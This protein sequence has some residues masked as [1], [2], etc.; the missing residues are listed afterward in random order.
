MTALLGHLGV[1]GWHSGE[2][3]RLRPMWP[4]FDSQMR[5]VF[6]GNYSFPSPQK[7]K[8]DLI[9]LIVNFSYSV[10]NQCS[11]TRTTRHLNKVPFLSFPYLTFTEISTAPDQ[12][13]AGVNLGEQ[14]PSSVLESVSYPA[15]RV[16]QHIVSDAVSRSRE[17]GKKS[18]EPR[19]SEIIILN[20]GSCACIILLFS[21]YRIKTFTTPCHYFFKIAVSIPAFTLQSKTW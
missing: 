9:V 18:R 5:E 4:G 19:I 21:Q 13:V 11:S 12:A 1:Q 17:N 14:G 16:M 10:P 2:S 7:P 20:D 8:F 6:S 15:V 3:T